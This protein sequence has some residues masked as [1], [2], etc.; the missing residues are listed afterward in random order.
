MSHKILPDYIKKHYRDSLKDL[1]EAGS[2]IVAAIVIFIISIYFG[3]AYPSWS[4]GTLASMK[5]LAKDL[6]GKSIYALVF[7]IFLKNSL[8][9]SIS[10]ISGPFLG[11]I[12]VLGAIINGLLL[13]S[14][15]SYV[16]GISKIS[17]TL[18][19]LP[20]GLFEFPAMFMAWG[21]GLWQGAWFFQKNRKTS[22]KERRTRAIRA[23]FIII[24]PLL[25]IA[26]T[27][28]GTAIYMMK[29]RSMI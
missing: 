18:Y 8:S 19:L 3:L 16:T 20:H 1:R 29:F 17:A 23:L 26:A 12:P 6:Y 7:T 9:T 22:L 13:G 24:L 28:E 21:L 11:I 10:V 2:A 27:I 4:E 14:T 5:G 25:L 15:L